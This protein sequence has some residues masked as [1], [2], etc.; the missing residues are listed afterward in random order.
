MAN[1]SI[2]NYVTKADKP[3]NITALLETYV[4]TVDTTKVLRYVGVVP[5]GGSAVIGI[6]I[7]DT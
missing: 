2:T 6:V 3:E 4:E 1:Y 7:H 5:A